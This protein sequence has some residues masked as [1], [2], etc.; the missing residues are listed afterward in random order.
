MRLTRPLPVAPHWASVEP[1]RE[2]EE[3][4]AWYRRQEPPRVWPSGL[5]RLFVSIQ[6]DVAR[7]I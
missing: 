1:Q 3:R 7:G 4:L 6:L 2:F 5:V